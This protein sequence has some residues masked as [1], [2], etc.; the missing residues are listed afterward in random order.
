VQISEYM[1]TD[2]SFF[3]FGVVGSLG[4]ARSNI[5]RGRVIK[6]SKELKM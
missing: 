1:W 6:V 5:V 2:T 4:S 3:K